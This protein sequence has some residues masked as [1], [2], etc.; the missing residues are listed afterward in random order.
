MQTSA[1]LDDISVAS[2]HGVVDLD[3][4]IPFSAGQALSL[5]ETRRLALPIN[6]TFI[7]K[8][9]LRGA[10]WRTPF[11]IRKSPLSS[12]QPPVL[13]LLRLEAVQACWRSVPPFAELAMMPVVWTTCVGDGKGTARTWLAVKTTKMPERRCIL[14]ILFWLL[15]SYFFDF[16]PLF[17]LFLVLE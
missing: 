10:V 6:A 5:S 16:V 4:S 12:R 3:D 13:A 11:A 2:P 1:G 14:F 9:Y 7:G 17:F 15:L 8:F